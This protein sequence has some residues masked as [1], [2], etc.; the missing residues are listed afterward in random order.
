V[1]KAVNVVF[2]NGFRNTL[3]SFDIDVFIVKV[4]IIFSSCRALGKAT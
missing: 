4:P 3:G 1:D 2:S